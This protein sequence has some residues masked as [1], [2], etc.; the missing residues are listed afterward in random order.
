M[1]QMDFDDISRFAFCIYPKIIFI[2]I[3]VHTLYSIAFSF[4]F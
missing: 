1:E 3:Y 2:R 4:E